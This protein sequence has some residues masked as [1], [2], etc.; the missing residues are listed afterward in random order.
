MR[1]STTLAGL[2]LAVGLALPTVT[3]TAT[4]VT[5]GG[6]TAW[7]PARGDA[8]RIAVKDG[9]R[10][11]DPAKAEYFRTASSDRKRTLW[12]HNGTHT[13]VYS[14][15]GSKIFKFKACDE[16]FGSRDDCSGWA[17]N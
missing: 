15:D 3:A 5:G 17:Y 13:T 12:N 16:N 11:S 8:G 14:G 4:S 2:L 6:A 7:S 1:T 9:S 10:D